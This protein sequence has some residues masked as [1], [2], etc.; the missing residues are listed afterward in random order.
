LRLEP[1]IGPIGFD[2]SGNGS[3]SPARVEKYQGAAQ[4][5]WFSLYPASSIS[6]SFD[7]F[8]RE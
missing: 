3:G 4:P 5:S 8:R 1:I 6:E 7:E 2:A